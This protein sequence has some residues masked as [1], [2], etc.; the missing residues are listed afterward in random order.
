MKSDFEI[1]NS[2]KKESQCCNDGKA[3]KDLTRIFMDRLDTHIDIRKVED[4][5]THSNVQSIDVNMLDF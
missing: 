4:K 1:Q 5:V 2:R 3:L